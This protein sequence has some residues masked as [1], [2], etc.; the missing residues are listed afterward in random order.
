MTDI[1]KQVVETEAAAQATAKT[2]MAQLQTV[3][4]LNKKLNAVGTA[5]VSTNLLLD[6]LQSDNAETDAALSEITNNQNQNSKN[7]ENILS[8]WESVKNKQA[9]NMSMLEDVSQTI[10]Q[11]RA[12]QQENTLETITKIYDNADEYAQTAAKFQSDINA[13]TVKLDR[14]DN[15]ESI[16][17][18]LQLIHELN[19]NI[20][21]LSEQTDINQKRYDNQIAA[22]GVVATMLTKYVNKYDSSLTDLDSKIHKV[23]ITI[24]SIDARVSK[25][26]PLAY[27][28]D[29]SQ[30][31]TMFSNVTKEPESIDENIEMLDNNEEIEDDKDVIVDSK[32]EI[33]LPVHD[34]KPITKKSK[35]KFWK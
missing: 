28:M 9:Y 2:L 33:V 11:K 4:F 6:T 12:Q 25:I 31:M 7:T 10:E 29:E 30:I 32:Y 3:N 26:T 24:D 21:K 13:L 18:M 17:E 5:L 19:A 16:S 27:D 34:E 23:T 15:R 14:Y 22:I 1:T 35:W 20:E 8:M